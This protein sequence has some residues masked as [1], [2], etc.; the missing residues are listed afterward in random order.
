LAR[1]LTFLL[2]RA[3]PEIGEAGFP[4]GAGIEEEEGRVGIEKL[5][6]M[7]RLGHDDR[8]RPQGKGL[9]QD[10]QGSRGHPRFVGSAVFPARKPWV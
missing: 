1:S 4:V 10:L 3:K 9:A 6:F 5:V 2:S 7:E 8:A